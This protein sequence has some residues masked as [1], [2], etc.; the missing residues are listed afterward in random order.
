MN[1]TTINTTPADGPTCDTC[2]EPLA[3]VVSVDV[4]AEPVYVHASV[5]AAYTPATHLANLAAVA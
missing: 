2:G 3:R 4:M 5:S 1:G